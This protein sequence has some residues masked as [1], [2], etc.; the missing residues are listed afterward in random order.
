MGLCTHSDRLQKQ[1]KR[2]HLGRSSAEASAAARRPQIQQVVLFCCLSPAAEPGCL[3]GE[4]EK[5]QKQKGAA[6]TVGIFLS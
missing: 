4:L 6:L 5:E 3:D 1:R 2:G